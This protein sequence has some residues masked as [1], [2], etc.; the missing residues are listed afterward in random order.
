MQMCVGVLSLRQVAQSPSSTPP[1]A[2][3][4]A[5]QIWLASCS[6]LR[7]FELLRGYSV[8]SQYDIQALGSRVSAQ[9]CFEAFISSVCCHLS[10]LGSS[11]E[12]VLQ[13]L[14]TPDGFVNDP[15]PPK[16]DE[17]PTER[18]SPSF[19]HQW[20]S[21]NTPTRVSG[22]AHK[23]F[24]I[25]TTLLYLI[26]PVRGEPTTHSL[27]RHPHDDS[28]KY[29][30]LQKK[31]LDSFALISSTSRKGADTASAACLEQ[32][33]PSGTIL[34]LA[35]N[36]GVPDGLVSQLQDILDCLTAV[37]LKGI[38]LRKTQLG[39]HGTLIQPV[40]QKRQQKPRSM[41][42]CAESLFSPRIRS[43]RF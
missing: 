33:H 23:R 15:E 24:V 34:R 19:Q 13:I 32:G 9:Q 43:G 7:V 28:W 22:A 21:G 31:F 25:V 12:M 16:I 14:Q 39:G 30:Q 18:T 6:E 42:S 26:D 35:R 4:W 29:E 40:S 5:N 2:P 1:D 37:A 17:I 41:R 38:M 27:D 20:S 3:L 11:R 8:S 10:K 36:T